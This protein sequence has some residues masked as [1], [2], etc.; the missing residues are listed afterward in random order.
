[1]TLTSV[2]RTTARRASLTDV[3]AIVRLLT[4]GSLLPPEAALSIRERQS[5]LRLTLAHFGLEAGEVWIA[6]SNGGV[7][8]AAAVWIPP[9]A[10]IDEA[11]YTSLLEL[12]ELACLTTV[13]SRRQ[14]DPMR[15]TEEHW[16]LA[17][18]GVATTADTDAKEAVLRPVL[19]AADTAYLPAYACPPA[20]FQAEVL[21][22]FGFAGWGAGLLPKGASW[23]RRAPTPR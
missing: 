15:P 8:E 7:L 23:L 22:P 14:G 19:R 21:R 17:A 13:S 16:L 10:A 5:E 1:M 6:E 4:E 2:H 18:F 3:N 9:S 11:Q 20:S 12:H